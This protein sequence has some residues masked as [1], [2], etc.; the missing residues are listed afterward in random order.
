MPGR[1]CQIYLQRLRLGGF[2]V[3]AR[4]EEETRWQEEGSKELLLPRCSCLDRGLPLVSGRPRWPL[5][6]IS[7]PKVFSPSVCARSARPP[8]VQETFQMDP[9]VATALEKVNILIFLKHKNDPLYTY[10]ASLWQHK[11]YLWVCMGYLGAGRG[12]PSW[13]PRGTWRSSGCRARGWGWRR[14]SR[15]SRRGRRGTG[16]QSGSTRALWSTRNPVSGSEKVPKRQRREPPPTLWGKGINLNKM[17]PWI[18]DY[19]GYAVPKIEMM[20]SENPWMEA[21]K[22]DQFGS[23]SN[24]ICAL[25]VQNCNGKIEKE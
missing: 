6:R 8:A 3:C 14:E 15:S 20:Q 12:E 18:K 21:M 13:K 17:W 4:W 19:S 9:H 23:M 22:N 16:S 7:K 5:K 11:C 24:I 10:W 1:F 25:R 2:V